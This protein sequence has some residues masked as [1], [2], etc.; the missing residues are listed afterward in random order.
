MIK[1]FLSISTLIFL[2]IVLTACGGSDDSGDTGDN[3]DTDTGETSTIATDDEPEL[4]FTITGAVDAEYAGS[5]S[6]FCDDGDGIGNPFLEIGNIG[7]NLLALNIPTEVLGGTVSVI[8][9]DDDGS[10]PG[11]ATYVDY[12]DENRNSYDLGTGELVIESMPDE[13]GDVF[14][15]TLNMELNDEDGNAVTVVA[16][17]AVEAGMQSFD[18]CNG[19]GS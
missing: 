9:S 18:D 17:Y 6:L 7:T 4:S 8:G 5:A 19:E 16:D 11:A 10:Q 13:E 1:R 14:I 15:A 2:S 3:S 12:T